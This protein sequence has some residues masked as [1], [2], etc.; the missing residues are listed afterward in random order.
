MNQKFNG[1]TP[2]LWDSK[3]CGQENVM[4]VYNDQFYAVI[5]KPNRGKSQKGI[6]A[7]MASLDITP[8]AE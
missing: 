4:V 5:I 2:M 8:R 1:E 3:N 6:K 7:A